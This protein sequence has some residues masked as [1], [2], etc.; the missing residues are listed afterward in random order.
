[1]S[2]AVKGAARAGAGL[3]PM[4][5]GQARR[6]AALLAD[7]ASLLAEVADAGAG[8]GA[9][10][11]ADRQPPPEAKPRPRRPRVVP[12]VA[13]PSGPVDDLTAARARKSLCRLGF[14][15]P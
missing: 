2:A 14:R 1:M 5:P 9:G 12:L 8:A 15:R 6:A 11:E 10:S 7:L 3:A 13:A 4:T